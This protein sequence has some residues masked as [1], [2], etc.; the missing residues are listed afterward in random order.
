VVKA[1]R[2]TD[3]TDASLRVLIVEDSEDDAV[4]LL[5]ELERGGYE[6]T[7]ERVDTPEAMAKALATRSWDVVLSDWQMPRFSAT[8]ALEM[9]REM[10][11]KAPFI[12][13]SGRGADAPRAGASPGRVA[14]QP[15]TLPVTGHELL[16]HDHGLRP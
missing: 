12:I 14:A 8:G 13:V 6:P 10:N 5:R 1:D 16:G 11:A 15:R 3:G 7:Y 2:G 4:L 9:L